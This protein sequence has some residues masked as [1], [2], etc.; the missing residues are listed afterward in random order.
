[1]STWQERFETLE[2]EEKYYRG[3]Y[4]GGSR[5]EA[6]FDVLRTGEYAYGGYI[7]RQRQ[8]KEYADKAREEAK[9]EGRGPTLTEF[10]EVYKRFGGAIVE[11][12]VHGIKHR[13]SPSA[14]LEVE[15]FW[16]S[17]ATDIAFDPTTYTGFGLWKLAKGAKKAIPEAAAKVGVGPT[18]TG[19]G[20]VL[21]EAFV[22]GYWMKK[23]PGKHAEYFDDYLDWVLRKRGA[24]EQAFHELKV[25]AKPHKRSGA[26]ITRYIES[27]IST[28]DTA[29]NKYIDDVIKPHTASM[30][31]VELTRGIDVGEVAGYVHHAITK[32]GQKF[33]KRMGGM[34]EVWKY[35]AQKVRAP[36]AKERTLGGT[37]AE[38]NKEFGFKFFEEDFWKATAKRTQKHV[39]DIYTADWFR[40]VQ[41]KYGIDKLEDAGRLGIDFVESAHPQIKRLLPDPI[42]KHLEEMVEEPAQGFMPALGRKHDVAMTWWKRAVTVGFGVAIHPAFFARNVYSG[43]YQ[44]WLRTGL[45][46]P[47]DYYRGI[48]ARLGK[49]TFETAER[50]KISGAEMQDILREQSIMGQPGMMDVMLE[51]VWERNLY[52]KIR[53]VPSWFMT[54]TENLVR[55]PEFVRLAK[56]KTLQE[57]RDITYETHFAYLPEFHTKFEMQYAKRG[58]PFYTWMSRDIPF[59]IKQTLK[60]PSKLGG[61]G[62]VQ[63]QL[64]EKYGMEE[65]YERR[66][67]WQRNMFLI[68]NIFKRGEDKGWI[69][70]GMPFLDLTTDLGDLYF[71]L[72]PLKLIPEL[73]YIEQDWGSREYRTEKQK[74]AIRRLAEGRYGTTARRL[75]RTEGDFEK[76]MYLAG[77]PTYDVAPK[78]IKT[79]FEAARYHKPSPTKEQE[80]AAWVAAGGPGGFHIKSLPGG[81]RLALP[82]ELYEAAKGFK[83]TEKQLHYILTGLK[84]ALPELSAL[85][86]PMQT[87]LGDALRRAYEFPGSREA[88]YEELVAEWRAFKAGEM[89][90]EYPTEAQRMASWRRAGLAPGQKYKQRIYRDALGKL[91]GTATYTP[92]EIEAMGSWTPSETEAEWAFRE[93]RKIAPKEQLKRWAQE[94]KDELLQEEAL[95]E[96]RREELAEIRANYA[97]KGEIPLHQR[98]GGGDARR[99]RR[100]ELEEMLGVGVDR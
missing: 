32:E 66:T 63:Q 75:K 80:Y 100:R 23:L 42:A 73:G 37:I 61:V 84:T 85:E 16:S 82:H 97:V 33:V 74:R 86:S 53:D 9:R 12:P 95:E 65:E 93:T 17:L 28:G 39:G 15:G 87:V 88:R 67:E 41:T 70:L 6:I 68:P 90:L 60:Q 14:V 64:I 8:L 55:I 78:D 31:E 21:G 36:Y 62:K 69:G 54:E 18:V 46:N 7:L 83:P 72:S 10:Y 26:D 1:M 96:E 91:I 34:E 51:D 52:E 5:L 43:V 3:K 19:I 99:R 94:H 44:N 49:G 57:A 89:Q 79:A 29:L 59:Q 22:P 92:D 71:A 27:G 77:M 98:A 25:M 2:D 38:V 58:F 40:Q 47:A 45:W 48:Q 50:G 56:T 20:Q 76:A 81:E 4:L 30:R 35:Y 24:A 11:G 13:I